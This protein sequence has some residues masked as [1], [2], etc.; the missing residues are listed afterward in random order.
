MVMGPHENDSDPPD[1]E[2]LDSIMQSSGPTDAFNDALGRRRTEATEY[3]PET[4]T[5]RTALQGNVASITASVVALGLT[6]ACILAIGLQIPG[7]AFIAATCGPAAM[8]VALAALGQ[9]PFKPNI[10]IRHFDD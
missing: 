9:P 4:R 1:E 2:D 3:T 5:F 10:T 7:A 8:S 6:V